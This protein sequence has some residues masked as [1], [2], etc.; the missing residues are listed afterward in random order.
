MLDSIGPGDV[1]LTIVALGGLFV[2]F[3]FI[4]DFVNWSKENPEKERREEGKPRKEKK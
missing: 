1:F 3:V 2:A 4:A